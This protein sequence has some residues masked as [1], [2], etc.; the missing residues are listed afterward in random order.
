MVTAFALIELK[1]VKEIVQ[2][3][4]KYPCLL[5]VAVVVRNG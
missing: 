3:F 1:Y 4:G 2:P 5:T